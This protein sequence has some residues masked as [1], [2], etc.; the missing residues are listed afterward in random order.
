ML[1]DIPREL[2]EPEAVKAAAAAVEAATAAADAAAAELARNRQLLAA[3]AADIENTR[4]DRTGLLAKGAELGA[5]PVRE[6]R[7]LEGERVALRDDLE[8]LGRA[9]AAR[10]ESAAEEARQAAV[11]FEKA[12]HSALVHLEAEVSEALIGAAVEA[13]APLVVILEALSKGRTETLLVDPDPLS[14]AVRRVLNRVH[15]ALLS[16]PPQFSQAAALMEPG[17]FK[18]KPLSLCQR[19]KRDHGAQAA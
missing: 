2:I 19:H 1:P 4:R 18:Y 14:R 7:R 5:K 17:R 13:L 16:K 6:L 9:L 8:E 10:A 3:A 15:A 11:E 12:R